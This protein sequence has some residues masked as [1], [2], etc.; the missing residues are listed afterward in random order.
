M[1]IYREY[2]TDP[3]AEDRGV[4]IPLDPFDDNCQIKLSY[5]K[6][7]RVND[8]RNERVKESL[9]AIDEKKGMK[10]IID[11]MA[12]Q[13][14]LDWKGITKDGEELPFSVDTAKQVFT[15]LPHFLDLVFTASQQLG[16]FKVYKEDE[17]AKN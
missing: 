14:V 17:D 13:V 12:E 1:D 15:E 6:C 10:I 7:D 11:V 3:R 4:W 16:N 8:F 2:Q 9:G 5:Y